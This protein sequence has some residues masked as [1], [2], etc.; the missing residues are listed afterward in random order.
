MSLTYD[1][2]ELLELFCSEPNIIDKDAEI[3]TYN[4]EDKHGFLFKLYFSVY[5][6]RA[7]VRLE[8]KDLENPVFD[9]EL[10]NVKK[11]KADSEKLSIYLREDKEVRIY[12][13][14]SFTLDIDL[15]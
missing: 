4:F 10:S 12:F 5:D 9:I 6:E 8:N 11:I 1:G 7:T 13:K 3:F 14:P 15:P 2:Y